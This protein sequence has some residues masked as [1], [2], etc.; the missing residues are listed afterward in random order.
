MSGVFGTHMIFTFPFSILLSVLKLKSP[1]RLCAERRRLLL[2]GR[3]CDAQRGLHTMALVIA[4]MRAGIN[5]F[6]HGPILPVVDCREGR[7]RLIQRQ[8]GGAKRCCLSARQNP[9]GSMILERLR[10]AEISRCFRVPDGADNRTLPK[11]RCPECPPPLV[12]LVRLSV[13]AV[14]ACCPGFNGLPIPSLHKSQA[15]PC[16]LE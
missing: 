2:I 4:E 16:F 5:E 1:C 14:S 15:I 12:A 8:G 11:G 10:S 13:R 9:S 7:F 6:R 3:R